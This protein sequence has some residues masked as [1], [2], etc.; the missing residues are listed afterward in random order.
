MTMGILER[1]I[2]RHVLIGTATALGVLVALFSILELVDDLS[3]VGRG[4]YTLMR[5]LEYS[6]L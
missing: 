6:V 1:Y 4:D 3:D 2:A 5:A